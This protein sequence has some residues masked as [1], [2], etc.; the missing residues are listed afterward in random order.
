MAEDADA[1]DSAPVAAAACVGSPASGDEPPPED[2]GQQRPPPPPTPPSPPPP[3]TSTGGV[4]ANLDEPP[5]TSPNLDIPLQ[6][7]EDASPP[8]SPPTESPMSS[9]SPPLRRPPTSPSCKRAGGTDSRTTV[10]NGHQGHVPRDGSSPQ[11]RKMTETGEQQTEEDKIREYL[12]RSDTAVI[13]P[14]PVESTKTTSTKASS[15]ESNLFLRFATPFSGLPS[16]KREAKVN[17]LTASMA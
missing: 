5:P 17:G 6:I 12:G 15:G 9:P 16:Y 7:D 11:C 8:P 2:P 14:E 13:F 1:V 10:L 3:P 4:Q